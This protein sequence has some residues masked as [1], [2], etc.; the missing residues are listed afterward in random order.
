MVRGGE[1][2]LEGL[3]ICGGKKKKIGNDN[4]YYLICQNG[5]ILGPTRPVILHRDCSLTVGALLPRLRYC[6]GRS[7]VS[8]SKTSQRFNL[9][10]GTTDEGE[11]LRYD[12]KRPLYS[13]THL[14]F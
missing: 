7:H 14:D 10:G 1:G 3:Y 4:I 8:G 6:R 13:L 5:S 9:K 12:L 2:W 11:S